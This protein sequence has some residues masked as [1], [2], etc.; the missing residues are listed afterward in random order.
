MMD[1]FWKTE[2]GSDES[3][4]VNSPNVLYKKKIST[5]S[6]SITDQRREAKSH[7]LHTHGRQKKRVSTSCKTRVWQVGA[8]LESKKDY[9][10]W[11][12]LYDS[13]RNTRNETNQHQSSILQKMKLVFNNLRV[14]WRLRFAIWI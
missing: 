4:K 2:V 9:V 12:G 6:I 8:K 14:P 7:I 11:S 13:L 1:L 5:S 3:E 10:S